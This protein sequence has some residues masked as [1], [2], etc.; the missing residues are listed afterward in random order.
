MKI[1]EIKNLSAEELAAQIRQN[2]DE[3]RSLR[4]KHKSTQGIQTPGQITKLRK[5]IARLMTVANEK[6]VTE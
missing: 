1:S 2:E 5:T 6:K 4:L 3:L